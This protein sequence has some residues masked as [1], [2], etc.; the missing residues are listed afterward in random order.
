[1]YVYTVAA[2]DAVVFAGAPV[3]AHLAR[4]VQQPVPATPA[5]FPR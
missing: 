5:H 3:S 1:M 4:D 2:V